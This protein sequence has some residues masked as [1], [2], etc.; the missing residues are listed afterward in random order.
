[1][2]LTVSKLGLAA[3]Q[4]GLDGMNASPRSRSPEIEA[5]DILNIAAR[6]RLS[7]LDVSGVYGRSESVLGDLIPRPVSCRVTLAAA[8]ADRGPDFVEAE[9]RASLRRMGLERADTIVVQSPSELFGA[10]GPAMWDRLH[11]LR[12]QGLFRNIGISAHATDDPVGVARRFKPDIIQAPAS[13]L[14]QRLL[15]D[16]SLQ[17]IAGMGV[18]VQLRSIFL[19][20][21]LFLPPD[22]VPAQLKGASGRLSRV[23]RMIAEGRSDPLQAALGFA[24]SRPEASAVIVGVTSAA[25]LSAVVAAASS[26][27]PDLDWDEMAIDD[28]VAL[29]PRRWV[30]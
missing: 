14:D 11:R 2:S 7:V 22:R 1:M 4:F 23:R 18:E 25:E 9:A 26:P 21:L 24:L 28:P 16:G 13:L 12:E 30:A 6:A 29:D 20:G 8:R 19:N 10:H 17:R 3:A 5:R 15:A 27:P